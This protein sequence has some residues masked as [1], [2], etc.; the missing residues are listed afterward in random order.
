MQSKRV[1]TSTVPNTSCWSRRTRH[2]FRRTTAFLGTNTSRKPTRTSLSMAGS[3][4][5][6]RLLSMIQRFDEGGI[7]KPPGEV[8]A[9][10]QKA[11][12]IL[13]GRMSDPS[14]RKVCNV[15]TIIGSAIQLRLL[16]KL[17]TKEEHKKAALERLGEVAEEEGI[18]P[19]SLLE[20][21]LGEARRLM[22]LALRSLK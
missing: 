4:S 20:L 7:D 22:I 9:I 15:E 19:E 10:L 17:R 14:Y 11:A 6:G 8:R 16:Q 13:A 1:H 21:P 12:E 18:S 3:P 2:H 5:S